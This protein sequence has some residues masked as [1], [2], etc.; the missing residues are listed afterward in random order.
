MSPRVR[1]PPSAMTGTPAGPATRDDVRDRGELRHAHARHDARRADRAGPDADLDARRRRRRSGRARAS[2]VAMLPATTSMSKRFLMLA[3]RL[4]HV[5]AVAVRRVHH[6]H[7]H[8]GAPTSASTRS[9]SCTPTAAP[10]R[11]RPRRVAARR[12]GS[13][14]AGSMSRI[15]IRPASAPSLVHQ[16]QL[17]DLVAV[18]DVARP[19]PASCSGGAVTRRSWSS[20]PARGV[21]SS[22]GSAG[23]GCVRMPTTRRRPR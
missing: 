8:V 16:Q 4:D 21:S 17:L 19:A 6:D 10:T 18:Q 22:V 15:V 20:P 13:A 5:A 14:R 1:M 7:V 11:S 23:R 12:R 2:A 9:Q 3:H